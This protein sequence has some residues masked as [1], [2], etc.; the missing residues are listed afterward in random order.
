MI[1]IHDQY[2]TLVSFK[3]MSEKQTLFS[4]NIKERCGVVHFDT[5]SRAE[6]TSTS[7][8]SIIDEYLTR[9]QFEKLGAAAIEL[10]RASAEL[11]LTSILHLDMAYSC[12]CME[13]GSARETSKLFL[14]QFQANAKFYTNATT[15]GRADGLLTLSAWHPI[16]NATFDSGIL[17]FDEEKIGLIWLEDED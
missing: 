7:D 11:F 10:D 12:Q 17:A 15:S 6:F 9:L 1:R 13:I 4:D 16:T 2:P 14:N 3:S 8:L 5:R